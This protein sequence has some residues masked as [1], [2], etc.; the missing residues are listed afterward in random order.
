MNSTGTGPTLAMTLRRLAA[1]FASAG[2]DTPMLDARLLAADALGLD[3]VQLLRD[4]DRVLSVAC[5]AR[6]DGLAA[7]R[8][9]R[10]PVSRILGRRWFHGLEFAIEP[11]T[12]DPRP[13][14]ETLVDG[15]LTRARHGS[16][17]GGA[18]CRILDLGT[19]SGAI[20]IALLAALP[21]ATGV[22]TDISEAA[23]AV[24]RGNARRHGVDSRARFQAAEWLQGMGGARFDVVV[25]NPPYIARATI[26]DLDPE[27]ARYEPIEALD[28]GP[29][30]L[31]AY[32]AIIGAVASV[33]S[34]GGL[35]VLEI[36][37]GQAEPVTRMCL[38]TRRL[39]PETAS[40]VW[41]D[42]SGHVRCV[43]ATAR[44]SG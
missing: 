39:C 8:L 14:T 34:P 27:V 15:V 4:P 44:N 28:G 19:G 31:E 1:D 33:L 21:E 12:L 6:I 11:A 2:I 35:L 23:L 3:P 9:Q 37:L 43:A 7:R 30:G 26:A 17:P 41:H 18:R 25:S 24:A 20:L 16:V 40:P 32:R 22:G 42:L 36:G 38:E 13:E 5:T 10:E 29:D